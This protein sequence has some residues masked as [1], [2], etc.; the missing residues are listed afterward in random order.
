MSCGEKRAGSPGH[1][2]FA[3]LERINLE[4]YS[5]FPL[6]IPPLLEMLA[7]CENERIEVI[8]AATPGPVGLAASVLA[9]ALD[10]PLIGTSRQCSRA[11]D[12]G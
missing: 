10:L 8:H 3:A 5:D 11:A 9:R 4:V 6:D 2:Q 1:E 7:W 12:H